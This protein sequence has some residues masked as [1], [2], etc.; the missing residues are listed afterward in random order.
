[1]T[2]REQ[3]VAGLRELLDFLEANPDFPTP[4]CC[5]AHVNAEDLAT[6]LRFRSMLGSTT[7]H[8]LDNLF[9]LSH[10][11]GPIRIGVMVDRGR[12]CERRVTTKTRPAINLPERTVEVVEWVCPESI[13]QEV[14]HE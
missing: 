5:S 13:L 9:W 8:S 7:K 12:V 11:F 10:S 14:G 1:M 3:F 2:E 4:L 6:L